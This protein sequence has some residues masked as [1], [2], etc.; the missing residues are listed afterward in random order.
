MTETEKERTE[1]LMFEPLWVT[2][3]EKKAWCEVCPPTELCRMATHIAVTKNEKGFTLVQQICYRCFKEL[4]GHP[5]MSLLDCVF[6]DKIKA[7]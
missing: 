5:R 1:R 4:D 2:D 7:I 6:Y 3:R